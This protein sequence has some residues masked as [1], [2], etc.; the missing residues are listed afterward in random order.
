[1][2][3]AWRAG[4]GV[5]K[6]KPLR[7]LTAMTKRVATTNNAYTFVGGDHGQWKVAKI[8]PVRGA[9]IDHAA[10]VDVVN[11]YLAALPAGGKW[12]LRGVTSNLRYTTRPEKARLSAVQPPLDRREAT[13]A[14]LIPI[15]KSVAWWELAQDERRRIF[16]EVS[17]HTATGLQFLPAVARRLHHSR[18]LNEPFDFLTWFEYAPEHEAAFENLVAQLRASEEWRYVERE[19]DIRLIRV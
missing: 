4:A 16:E 5:V 7:R 12:L 2:V 8:T 18:D 3:S 6:N 14:A 15:K 10:K 9:G 1:M 11:A 13:L 17:R 19:V